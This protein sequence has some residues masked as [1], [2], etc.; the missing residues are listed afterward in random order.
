MPSETKNA[1]SADDWA[2][3]ALAAIAQHGIEG[4]AIEPLARELSVTVKHQKEQG[5]E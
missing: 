2:E 4:V 1:L 5:Q 3:A